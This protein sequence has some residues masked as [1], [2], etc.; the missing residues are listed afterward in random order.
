[1][2]RSHL[3][4]AAGIATVVTVSQPEP[5]LVDWLASFIIWVLL[6]GAGVWLKRTWQRKPAAKDER[7]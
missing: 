6:I 7:P 2:N 1:M 5:H 4:W 3:Y